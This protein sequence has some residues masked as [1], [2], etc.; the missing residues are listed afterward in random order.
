MSTRSDS[1]PAYRLPRRDDGGNGIN[2]IV[3]RKPQV[4]LVDELAHTNVP[5]SR[6]TK[7]YEDVLE[8]LDAGIHVIR[9]STSSIWKR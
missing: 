3:Q 9:R 4:C 2:T 6:H 5:G 8:I 1:P 7:R